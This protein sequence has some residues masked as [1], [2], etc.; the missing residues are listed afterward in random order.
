LDN[1]QLCDLIANKEAGMPVRVRNTIALHNFIEQRAAKG[2]VGARCRLQNDLT[3]GKERKGND[4]L[5]CSAA[6][7]TWDG[8]TEAVPD[9]TLTSTQM[10]RDETKAGTCCRLFLHTW[11]GVSSRSAELAAA[12]V[13]ARHL[14]CR[15]CR[16]RAYIYTSSPPS[17]NRESTSNVPCVR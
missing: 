12:R 3:Q 5:L 16:T 14:T 15:P 11:C 4:P 6:S 7:R 9:P 10:R 8:P 17:V 2:M 1:T 13:T